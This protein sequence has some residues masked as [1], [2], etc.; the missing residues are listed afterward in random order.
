MVS[1]ERVPHTP[2]CHSPG[3][4]QHKGVLDGHQWAQLWTLRVMVLAT[5][6][7]PYTHTQTE[8]SPGARVVIVVPA[9][10]D[11]DSYSQMNSSGMCSAITQTYRQRQS[12]GHH[13][14]DTLTV[15][16]H[17]HVHACAGTS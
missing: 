14:R 3:P 13:L 12:T 6:L 16:D 10:Q 17:T 15:M 5:V 8:L 2:S 4:A 7:T 9:E 11:L 1:L